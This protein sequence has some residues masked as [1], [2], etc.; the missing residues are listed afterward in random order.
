[1]NTNNP[2]TAPANSPAN[3]GASPGAVLEPTLT[4]RFRNSKALVPT[5]AVMGVTVMALAAALVVGKSDA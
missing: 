1:M 2:A 4:E 5:M 3:R